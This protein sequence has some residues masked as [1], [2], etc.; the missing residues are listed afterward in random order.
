MRGTYGIVLRLL[1]LLVIG[2]DLLDDGLA[3]L[4][5]AIGAVCVP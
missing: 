2:A 4:E 1:P 3:I 5:K